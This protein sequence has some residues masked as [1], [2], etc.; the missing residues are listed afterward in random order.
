MGKK[1]SKILK[2]PP[3]RNC[4]T[5]AM[6]NNK[7]IKLKY[8]YTTYKFN[9]FVTC[10]QRDGNNQIQEVSVTIYIFFDAIIEVR[11]ESRNYLLKL[12]KCGKFRT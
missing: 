9:K 1:G 3:V 12:L 11:I 8:L 7:F 4:V 6:T 10:T 5:L 2:L